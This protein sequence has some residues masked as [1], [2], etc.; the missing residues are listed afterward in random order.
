ME[1]ELIKSVK[2]DKKTSFFCTKPNRIN[3]FDRNPTKGGIPPIEQKI[4]MKS[5]DKSLLTLNKFSKSNK[6]IGPKEL[7]IK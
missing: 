6:Y 3:I 4:K 7:L 1:I 2:K 5:R